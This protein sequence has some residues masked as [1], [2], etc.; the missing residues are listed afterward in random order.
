[1]SLVDFLSGKAR[2]VPVGH[3]LVAKDH[4]NDGTDWEVNRQQPNVRTTGSPHPDVQDI[5]H[6]RWRTSLFFSHVNAELDSVP[7]PVSNGEN[8]VT[9]GSLVT[10]FPLKNIVLDAC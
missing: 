2:E 5:C 3:N 10:L 4:I 1:M 8:V 7:A 6:V 9:E